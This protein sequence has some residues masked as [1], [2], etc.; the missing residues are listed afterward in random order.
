V[1]LAA[2]ACGAPRPSLDDQARQYVRLAVALGERDSDSLDFYAGAV[3]AVADIRRSPPPLSAIAHDAEGLSAAI[4]DRQDP[5]PIER[6]RVGALVRDL[7]AIVARVNL[8]N[9]ARPRYDQESLQFFGIAPPA[10]DASRLAAIRTEIA[11]R[12]G[13]EGRLVDRYAAFASRFT[14]P[15]DRLEPVM[16]AALAACRAA[17]R[18]QI[19]LPADED[20]VLEFVH[21][22]PWAAYSRY[23]G[24]GRSVIAINRDFG[25]T[26]DQAL[27][28]ACHEGY[29]GHHT[30][31]TLLTAPARDRL[32]PERLV[33]LTF[34]PESSRSEAAA[35][36]AADAAFSPGERLRLVRD[37]LLPLAHLRPDEAAVHIL[38]E[39]RVGAL[40][41]VQADVARRYLD[42]DLEFAR[43]STALEEEALVPHAE[44]LLK[45]INRYRSYVT[46]YTAGYADAAT[47][48]AACTDG[49]STD[50]IRWSCYKTELIPPR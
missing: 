50:E 13:G 5:D 22:K 16:A 15:A 9:G 21:D 28:V 17:T 3:D 12:V 47:R 2:W 39:Q 19:A 26:A 14:I 48:F 36:L 7:A 40:Q 44:A 6:E 49:R 31:N 23:R 27:Q 29:P 33:Q 24:G 35:M 1:L 46:T 42:G 8:L 30:R 32:W 20:A 11:T 18:P 41:I 45:Y 10:A 38:V 25:F 43:A 37:R 34:S 4:R